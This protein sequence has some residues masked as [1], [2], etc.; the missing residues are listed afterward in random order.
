MLLNTKQRQY[1]MKLHGSK[2][3]RHFLTEGYYCFYCSDPAQCLDHVP[4]L[5]MID[6]YTHEERKK[7][8]IPAVLLSCCTEC[9]SALGSRLLPTA[10]E[11]LLYLESYYEAFFKKQKAMWTD[12]EIDELGDSLKSSVRARQEKLN[13]YVD[14]I[15][16]IQ[17]RLIRVE[18]HPTFYQTED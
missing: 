2:Y 13:R 7:S 16:A 8:N 12:D 10:N 14:K 6:V 1:L 15:R 3:K 11:R 17:L 5:S 4:P 18:T 9:N